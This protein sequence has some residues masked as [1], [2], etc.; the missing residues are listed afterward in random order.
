MRPILIVGCQ[1]SGSTLLGSLLGG[2]PQI[3]TIPEAQFFVD[4]MPD[5]LNNTTNATQLMASIKAHYRFKIWNYS[6]PEY[7]QDHANYKQVFEWLVKSYACSQLKNDP[8]AWIDHQP[9]HVKHI[10]KIRKMYPNLKVIHIIRDGRA[11]ANSIVPLDWGPNSINRA[12]YYYEQ[13]IGFGLAAEQFLGPK[14][15]LQI[16]Y[17]NLITQPDVCLKKIC[18]FIGFDY[19][20]EMLKA[21]GL[22][23]PEFTK[24]QHA[25]VGGEICNARIDGWRTELPV[26]QQEIFELLTGDL[27]TY[28][29]YTKKF[30]SPLQLSLKERLLMDSSHL[31]KSIINKYKF[32]SRVKRNI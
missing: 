4:C 12:A 14:H 1:R 19:C 15:A 3:I 29:G 25:L 10:G 11:V 17:E 9:G 26:R 32:S 5:D 28:L 16:K 30:N 18:E 21:N 23:V 22:A 27:L 13:R 20:R 24:S 2:H 31:Y 8:L 6:V 7:P